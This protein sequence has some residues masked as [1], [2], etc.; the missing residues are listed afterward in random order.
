M[1]V[2]CICGHSSRNDGAVLHYEVSSVVV[3][4]IG[5]QRDGGGVITTV[6]R[7]CTEIIRV[8]QKRGMVMYFE[9]LLKGG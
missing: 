9:F 5:V 6:I 2:Y 7:D 3:I 4:K 1:V 8:V